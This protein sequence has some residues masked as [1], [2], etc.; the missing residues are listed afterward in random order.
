MDIFG[1]NVRLVVSVCAGYAGETL[2]PADFA[3]SSVSNIIRFP[4]HYRI[5][6]YTRQHAVAIEARE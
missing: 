6:T 4:P 2:Y 1:L 3:L 5:K